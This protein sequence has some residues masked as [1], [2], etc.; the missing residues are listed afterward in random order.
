[1]FIARLMRHSYHDGLQ[2]FGNVDINMESLSDEL[3]TIVR[4]G[5]WCGRGL[6]MLVKLSLRSDCL[7]AVLISSRPW[8]L[9]YF[10]I[11]LRILV[12]DDLLCFFLQCS[13]MTTLD[14]ESEFKELGYW[15]GAFYGMFYLT[16]LR[17]SR[18]LIFRWLASYSEAYTRHLSERSTQ[19]ASIIYLWQKS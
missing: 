11:S 4:K 10:V 12:E 13:V 2:S 19:S 7:W 17:T 6:L 9:L 18:M 15:S 1:M 14:D 16:V 3:I 5:M 8:R